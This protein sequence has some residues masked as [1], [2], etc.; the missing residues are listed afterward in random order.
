MSEPPFYLVVDACVIG[1]FLVSAWLDRFGDHPR[2]AGVA[3]REDRPDPGVLRARRALHAEHG[4]SRALDPG[5]VDEL[6]RLYP[7]FDEAER[8]AVAT[9]GLPRATVSQREDT[10]FLGP[11]INGPSARSWLEQA[12]RETQPWLFS[13]LGKIVAPWWV[14][15]TG[16]RMLNVHSAVLPHVPGYYA[17]ENVA[18]EGE[19]EAFERGAG[20]SIHYIDAGVDT[21]GLIRVER[22]VDPL[23]FDS[24]WQFKAKVYV[25]SFR[26][27]LRVAEDILD[28]AAVPAGVRPDPGPRGRVWRKRDFTLERR[29]QA[30]R[31]YLEM[32][33]RR[34][35]SAAQGL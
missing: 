7:Y 18:A 24:L 16:S 20:F 25:T 28:G 33:A 13:N 22:I 11:R 2:F 14:E 21:G 4:G 3:V 26:H 17:I 5:L 6:L 19:V 30:E 1:T 15:L 23:R 27:Y 12:C 31:A 29:A 8:A 35:A 9:H 32:K 10:I 34:K